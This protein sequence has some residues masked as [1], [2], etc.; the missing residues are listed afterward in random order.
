[1]VDVGIAQ[2]VVQ[3]AVFVVSVVAIQKLLFNFALRF[4]T[5]N[6][7]HFWIFSEF[8]RQL[9]YR[10]VPSCRKQQRL[11]RF[12]RGGDNGFNVVDKAHVQHA[13]GFVQHQHFQAAKIDAPAAHVVHQAAGGGDHNINRARQGFDLLSERRTAHQRYRA[14][15]F[16]VLR[17]KLGVFFHLLGKLARGREHQHARAFARLLAAFDDFLQAGQQKSGGFARACLRRSHDVLVCQSGGDGLRLDGRGF[18]VA[19]AFE[20]RENVFVEV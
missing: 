4:G 11:A 2:N 10:A 7:N 5:F 16:H 1:M 13:V 19:R 6:F 9:A 20:R 18:F 12:G 17:V 3:Q 15:P 8:A 14:H